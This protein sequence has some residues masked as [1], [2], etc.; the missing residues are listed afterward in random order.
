MPQGGFVDIPITVTRLN[1]SAGAFTLSASGL[2]Q[3]VTAQFVNSTLRLRAAADAPRTPLDVPRDITITATPRAATSRPCRAARRLPVR[4]SSNFELVG[5][6]TASFAPCAQ[7]RTGAAR[8]ARPRVQ[9]HRHADGQRPPGGRHRDPRTSGDPAGWRPPRR[10]QDP[11]ERGQTVR[12]GAVHRRGGREGGDVRRRARGADRFAAHV[13]EPADRAALPRRRL[14]RR[15][16]RQRLLR[17]HEGA[18]RQ[19]PGARPTRPSTTAGARCA[20][21]RRGWPRRGRSRSSRRTAPRT[22]PPTSRWTPSAPP[23]DSR[24]PTT[25]TPASPSRRLSTP[26]GRRSSSSGSTCAGR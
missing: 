21:R 22:R 17:R 3:G 13:R 26:S 23:A 24:S 15:A 6:G 12:R 4:V 2:P 11:P 10:R 1:G 5:S 19:R 8:G 7:R 25:T 16:R 14:Q 20:S 9:R 18:G